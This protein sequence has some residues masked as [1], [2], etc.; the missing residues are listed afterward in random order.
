MQSVPSGLQGYIREDTHSVGW[1]TGVITPLS[2][3]SLRLHS[4]SSQYIYGYLP[5]SMFDGGHSRVCPDGIGPGQIAY[6]I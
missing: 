4:I 1:E 6:G 5:P 3:I 2:T